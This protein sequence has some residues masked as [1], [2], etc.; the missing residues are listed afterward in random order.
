MPTPRCDH[1]GRFINPD[2][3]S[4]VEIWG[5]SGREEYR[6]REC[7]EE[8]F[9]EGMASIEVPDGGWPRGSDMDRI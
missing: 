6:H 1:C 3:D 9:A 5:E 2:D 8:I 4:V 7:D